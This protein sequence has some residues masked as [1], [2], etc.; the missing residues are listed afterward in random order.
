MPIRRACRSYIIMRDVLFGHVK[1]K[2][3]RNCYI[4]NEIFSKETY[5]FSGITPF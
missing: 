4:V 5:G 3:V 1:K 2:T